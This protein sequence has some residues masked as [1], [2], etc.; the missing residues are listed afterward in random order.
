MNCGITSDKGKPVNEVK[1]PIRALVFYTSIKDHENLSS[2]ESCHGCVRVRVKSC[3]S[4]SEISVPRERA[5]RAKG[6]ENPGG[7]NEEGV[8]QG[9]I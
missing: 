2:K 6:L 7:V 1:W 5:G 9:I 4:F 3:V 8:G